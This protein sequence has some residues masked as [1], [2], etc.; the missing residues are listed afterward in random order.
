MYKT[1]STV[2][3][4]FFSVRQLNSTSRLLIAPVRD[5]DADPASPGLLSRRHRC[6]RLICDKLADSD[7]VFLILLYQRWIYR[8]G[9]LSVG[10]SESP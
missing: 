6:A 9:E 4:D 1:L 5:Q 10:A 8:I 7:A 3:D 2:I